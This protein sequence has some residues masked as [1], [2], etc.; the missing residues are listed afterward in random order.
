M[1]YL[2]RIEGA[3]FAG[4]RLKTITV[5]AREAKGV[6]AKVEEV[7]ECFNMVTT[8]LEVSDLLLEKKM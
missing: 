1:A 8:K 3:I 7:L 6:I 2:R 5:T 4:R